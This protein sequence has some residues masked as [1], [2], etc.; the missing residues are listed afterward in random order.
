MENAKV[1]QRQLDDCVQTAAKV[2]AALSVVLREGHPVRG[3][4]LAE[5][6]KV[7]SVDEPAPPSLIENK[8]ET[9]TH[10]TFPPHGEA[11]L[12]LAGVTLVR[13]SK[14]LLIGF[15]NDGDGGEVGRDV[16]RLILDVE[17]ELTVWVG[18]IRRGKITT[19]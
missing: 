9:S 10:E 13:A 12:R 17:R 4:A 16:R 8:E 18:K 11:R 6:G 2:V 7:L 3:V 1:A 14:E 15:G 5:L 19:N